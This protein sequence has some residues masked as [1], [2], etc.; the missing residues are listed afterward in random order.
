MLVEL[1]L[2]NDDFSFLLSEV[3][4]DIDNE[5]TWTE[6]LISVA[7]LF[8]NFVE[9][10]VKK[11]LIDSLELE[12]LKT[13]AYTKNLFPATDYPA[14]ANRRTDNMGNS[15]LKRYRAKAINFDGT[16]IYVSTQFFNSDRDAV[17]DWYRR[18]L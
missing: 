1:Q 4:F 10:L 14:I 5:E 15:S 13:K 6:G 16:D 7:K 11:G 12:S 8:Y 18:H 17:I 9:D 3:P 2:D